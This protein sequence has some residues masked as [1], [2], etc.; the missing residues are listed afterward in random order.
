MCGDEGAVIN[1][2]IRGNEACDICSVGKTVQLRNVLIKKDKNN[3]NRLELDRFSKVV[4]KDDLQ[5]VSV[6]ENINLSEMN[7]PVSNLNMDIKEKHSNAEDNEY[8]HDRTK[9]YQG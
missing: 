4:R 6:N 9:G 3:L 1:V 8:D 5:I 7:L 2:R